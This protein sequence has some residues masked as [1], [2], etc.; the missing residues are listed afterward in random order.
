VCE[1]RY[2]MK[3]ERQTEIL[4]ARNATGTVRR[5]LKLYNE[6]L[7]VVQSTDTFVATVRDPLYCAWHRNSVQ[8][9]WGVIHKQEIQED[10]ILLVSQNNSSIR[11]I[12]ISILKWQD[13]G[14]CITVPVAYGTH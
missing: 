11:R 14:M 9:F 4:C 3:D 13:L 12:Y 8:Y 10:F 6:K 2:V 1:L 7:H 5:V